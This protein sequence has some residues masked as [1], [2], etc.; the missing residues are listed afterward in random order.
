LHVFCYFP[1]PDKDHASILSPLR[2]TSVRYGEFPRV[3]ISDASYMLGR[4]IRLAGQNQR[5]VI[6]FVLAAKILLNPGIL[7]M[8]ILLDMIKTFM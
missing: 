7:F 3:G 5:T 2:K 4:V 8:D 6:P 1:C